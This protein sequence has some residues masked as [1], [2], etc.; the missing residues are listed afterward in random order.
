MGGEAIKDQHGSYFGV[1][2]YAVD[3]M[4]EPLKEEINIHESPQGNSECTAL[5][6]TNIHDF[7]V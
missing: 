1:G 5:D 3:K 7:P 4:F 2:W 6:A